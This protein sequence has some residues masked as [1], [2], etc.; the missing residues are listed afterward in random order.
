[1]NMKSIASGEKRLA[2]AEVIVGACSPSSLCSRQWAATSS[3][4][5]R[6]PSDLAATQGATEDIPELAKSPGQ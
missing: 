1:M 6:A 5:R 3:R 4:R 2:E